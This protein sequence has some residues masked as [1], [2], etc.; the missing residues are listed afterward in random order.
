MG[1]V[2]ATVLEWR[3]SHEI[4]SR[5]AALIPDGISSN[6]SQEN[7]GEGHCSF[8]QARNKC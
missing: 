2:F 5:L 4:G 7:V 6:L 1:E 3:G 8:V